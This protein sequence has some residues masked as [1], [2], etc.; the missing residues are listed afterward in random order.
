MKQYLVT[1]T[2][3]LV[4]LVTLAGCA[5]Q[6]PSQ[7]PF[8]TE[9]SSADAVQAARRDAAY[10]FSLTDV[11]AVAVSRAGRYWVVDLR[12]NDGAGL[13]YAISTDGS[14]RERRTLR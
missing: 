6:R 9:I 12:A 1:L 8:A 2:L 7:A 11:S 4:T 10:R 3:T 5:D 14:I 13:H